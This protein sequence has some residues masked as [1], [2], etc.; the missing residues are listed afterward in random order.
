MSNAGHF[1]MGAQHHF[2]SHALKG[3][4]VGLEAVDDGV[5]NILYYETLLGRLN[6]RTGRIT[7]ASFRSE[8]VLTMSPDTSKQSSRLLTP[9]RSG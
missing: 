8:E 6:E 9:Q 2:I 1:K 5:W 3:D 4:N 7:G